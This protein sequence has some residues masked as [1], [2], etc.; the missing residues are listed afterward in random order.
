MGLLTV[1]GPGGYIEDDLPFTERGLDDRDI[2]KMSPTKFWMIGD[3]HISRLQII[4]PD[5]RLHS[6]AGRHAPKMNW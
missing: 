5:L 3:N 1:M 6:H 2:W 4:L